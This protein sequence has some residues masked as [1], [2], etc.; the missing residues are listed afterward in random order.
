MY[1]LY[2][3]H[4]IF[5]CSIKHSLTT[6]I[7]IQEKCIVMSCGWCVCNYGTYIFMQMICWSVPAITVY[8][9]YLK[10]L[11]LYMLFYY[12][13]RNVF[14][15]IGICTYINNIYLHTYTHTHKI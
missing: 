4:N 14:S 15:K 12:I 3:Q 7:S 10:Y 9:Y 1:I 13:I 11:L 8:I 5:S 2:K 6:E